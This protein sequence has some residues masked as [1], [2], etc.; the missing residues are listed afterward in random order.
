MNYRAMVSH[1][2][3][4]GY[5]FHRQARGSHELWRHPYRGVA[6]VTRSGLSCRGGLNWRKQLQRIERVKVASK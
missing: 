4:L 2:K 6:L 5:E 3:K 1:L